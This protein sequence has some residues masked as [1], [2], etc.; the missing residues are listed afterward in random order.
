MNTLV[1]PASD[2]SVI[3]RALE[4]LRSDGLV[5]F[6]TD[7]V[8]GVAAGAFSERGID[9][10]YE[11]KGREAAKAI[12]VLLG[13]PDQLGQVAVNLPPYARRLAARFWPGAMTLVV[14]R[15]PGLPP[16]LSQTPTVGVRMPDHPLAL[17]LLRLSGPLATTSANLSGGP[18]PLTAQDAL[19]QLDGRVDLVI[20]GGA[21]P[22]GLPSTVVDATQPNLVILR[23]GPISLV[24]LQGCLVD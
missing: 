15:H 3:T 6:P 21:C 11:A 9:R 8:Y 16:N 1:L 14:P 19:A 12:P 4:V 22:G 24:D 5:V 7:T 13:S 18:N 2:P 17:A 20:D 10:L 23:Q